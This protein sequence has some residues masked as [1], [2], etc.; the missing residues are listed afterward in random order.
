MAVEGKGIQGDGKA[1]K[2]PREKAIEL[3]LAVQ[4]PGKDIKWEEQTRRRLLLDPLEEEGVSCRR[5]IQV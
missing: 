2:Q 5:G 1:Q 3:E 4:A